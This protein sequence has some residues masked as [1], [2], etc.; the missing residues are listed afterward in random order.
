VLRVNIKSK[1]IVE[2]GC[3]KSPSGLKKESPIQKCR[4]FLF[5]P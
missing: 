4:G 1:P 2:R 3:L 5:I